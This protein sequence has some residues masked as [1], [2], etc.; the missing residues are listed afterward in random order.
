MNGMKGDQTKMKKKKRRN[1]FLTIN[2][3]KWKPLIVFILVTL[4]W[5]I[6]WSASDQYIEVKTIPLQKVLKT[7]LDWHVTAYNIKEGG[8]TT[9][10]T[11]NTPAKICFWNDIEKKEESCFKAG[12]GPGAFPQVK[13]LSLV[14]LEK[15]REPRFG[16]LFV[17]TA[18]G[19]V[20]PLHFI[21]IWAYN[22][23]ESRFENILAPLRLNSQGE[24]KFIRLTSDRQKVIFVTANRIWAGGG[25]MLYGPHKFRINIY[26]YGESGMFKSKEQYVTARKY[27]SFEDVNKIDV[28]CH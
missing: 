2:L 24:Y 21:S 4:F 3:T 15:D 19:A 14:D 13:E 22:H 25:E 8:G 6:S 27:P 7:P 11:T 12:E 18:Y 20:E 28:R 1:P 26:A 9:F 5:S 10:T 17:A 23:K 16:I